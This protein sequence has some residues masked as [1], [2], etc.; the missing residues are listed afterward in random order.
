MFTEV[1]IA[2]AAC[3]TRSS[4]D[5]EKSCGWSQD[6]CCLLGTAALPPGGRRY[7]S[8]YTWASCK[9]KFFFWPWW[10]YHFMFS[11]NRLVLTAV[12][13]QTV[14][15]SQTSLKPVFLYFLLNLYDVCYCVFQQRCVVVYFNTSH[16]IKQTIFLYLEGT[17]VSCWHKSSVSI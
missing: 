9:S 6:G 16:H 17:S 3:G 12:R 8:H 14:K 7:V 2:T 10:R 13:V 1:L 5:V 4:P 11:L 15:F